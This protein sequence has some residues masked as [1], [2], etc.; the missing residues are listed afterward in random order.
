MLCTL[1][2]RAVH[3]EH[4]AVP[5]VCT[6]LV[7]NAKC[8]LADMNRN[9]H[10]LESP[11]TVTHFPIASQSRSL[12]PFPLSFLS[13]VPPSRGRSLSLP[14]PPSL[15]FSLSPFPLSRSLFLSLSLS[16][17]S[18]SRAFLYA[19]SIRFLLCSCTH[20]HTQTQTLTSQQVQQ[21]HSKSY[22]ESARD[23]RIFIP[24]F[25]LSTRP[26]RVEQA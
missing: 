13:F 6:L 1:C 24:P 20:V 10:F 22:A 26:R 15:P 19:A 4:T 8:V 3:T 25:A 7:G 11:F 16:H 18:I 9:A 12:T 5:T 2:A 14:A 17:Q 23:K 21:T